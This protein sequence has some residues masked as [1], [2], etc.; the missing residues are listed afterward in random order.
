M[1]VRRVLSVLLLAVVLAQAF[2]MWQKAL[3]FLAAML[4]VT[5][6]LL[7]AFHADAWR[8]RRRQDLGAFTVEQWLAE[9]KVL[10][11]KVSI[12]VSLGV[13]VLIDRLMPG[14]GSWLF[15][16]LCMLPALLGAFFGTVTVHVRWRRY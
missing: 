16:L 10:L 15:Y 3:V 11:A 9:D 8:L 7:G 5:A 4:C 12:F 2:V 13:L 14:P 1:F 6:I